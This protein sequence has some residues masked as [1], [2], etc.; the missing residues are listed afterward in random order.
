MF[1]A[2]GS[3]VLDNVFS[4]YNACIFAYGM[5][6]LVYHF[7]IKLRTLGQTGSGKTYTMMG[8]KDDDGVTVIPVYNLI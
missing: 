7:G 1:Q 5:L 3:D 2:L 6:S 8:A 4:G